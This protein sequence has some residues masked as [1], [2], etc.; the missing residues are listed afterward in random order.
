MEEKE[1]TRE[2]ELRALA[3]DILTVEEATEILKVGRVAICRALQRGTLP[4]VKVGGVWRISK[5]RL[6]EYLQGKNPQS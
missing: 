1:P 4:G 2:Q 5:T 3:E 6:M